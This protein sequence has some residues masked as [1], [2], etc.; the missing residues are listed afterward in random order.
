MTPTPSTE[1]V[2]QPS[3]LPGAPPNQPVA[4]KDGFCLFGHVDDS[5]DSPCR[6]GNYDECGYSPNAI[7]DSQVNALI[8]QVLSNASPEVRGSRD[9]S[10]AIENAIRR[11][12]VEG[13]T[14]ADMQNAGDR[15]S[16]RQWAFIHNNRNR[17]A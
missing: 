4:Y 17:K 14:L 5:P 13:G 10:R 6:A 3:G 12:H 8:A 9:A 2:Q 1:T 11:S 16:H 15:E 7:L